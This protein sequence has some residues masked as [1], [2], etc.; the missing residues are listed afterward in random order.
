LFERLKRSLGAKVDLDTTEVQNQLEATAV[1]EAV[2]RALAKVDV[3]NA[4]SLVVDDEVIFQDSD[5]KADDLP[6]LVLALAEHASVFGRGFRELRFAAEHE[7]AGLHL[8]IETRAR[9]RHRR[10]DPAAVVSVGGRIKELEARP[11]ETAESYRARVEPLINDPAR[12]EAARLSFE[13][14]VAR[15]RD[16]LRGAMPEAQ[17]EER[18]PEARLV[19]APDR[20]VAAPERAQREPT[21]PGYDPFGYYYPSPVGLMLDAMLFT[22][23][24]H[25]M[26]P[27]AVMVMSPYGSPLGDMSAIQSHPELASDDRLAAESDHQV[28]NGDGIGAGDGDHH[29][30]PGGAGSDDNPGDGAGLADTAGHDHDTAGGWGDSDWG[31]GDSGGGDWGGGGW[32]GGG[33]DGGGSLD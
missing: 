6:D 31:G 24:M 18:R 22:S 21:H 3:G 17:I 13:S 25:M 1:V 20:Q 10:Q 23:F 12:F 2:R 5:G 8:V 4:L 15:L 14:F 19:K 16:A 28:G 29:D 30:D 27:P 32:D 11:G 7:E 9:T 26:M 33:F